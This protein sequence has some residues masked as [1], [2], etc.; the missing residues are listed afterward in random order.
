[1]QISRIGKKLFPNKIING[2]ITFWNEIEATSI[3]LELGKGRIDLNNVV[4]L[5]EIKTDLE[6]KLMIQQV[7]N[8]LNEDIENL[9]S[10]INEQKEKIA[11]DKPKVDGWN[12]WQENEGNIKLTAIGRK[13]NSH[14]IM[15]TQWLR[16]NKI[17]YH[18]IKKKNA[19]YQIYISLN[20]NLHFTEKIVGT[21]IVKGHTLNTTEWFFTP[22][23]AIYYEYLYR[24]YLI[25]NELI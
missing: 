15:F 2:K 22:E 1:M 10:E 9:K 24:N 12:T 18:N 16:D 5:P 20:N 3:K 14:P 19:P 13:V 23:G 7:I 6:K 4:K 17:I 21:Y 11:L 8:F 25:E